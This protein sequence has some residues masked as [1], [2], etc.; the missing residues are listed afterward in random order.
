MTMRDELIEKLTKEEIDVIEV[1]IISPNDTMKI[2]E[3]NEGIE[4]DLTDQQ[5][6][7]YVEQLMD[8]HFVGYLGSE[9]EMTTA[10]GERLP[11]SRD[12][13][14]TRNGRVWWM[15]KKTQTITTSD[16]DEDIP[17]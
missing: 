5:V 2:A 17:F 10:P 8:K 6:L 7:Y 16:L 9:R 13:Y 12:Y 1:F 4:S 15:E 3:I 11:I 14:L